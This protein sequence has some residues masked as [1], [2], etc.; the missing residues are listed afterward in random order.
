MIAAEASVQST[1]MSRLTAMIPGHILTPT[2]LLWNQ[3]G[4]KLGRPTR[5]S[6]GHL[7][8]MARSA[9]NQFA[10]F[11]CSVVADSLGMMRL[12]PF[13]LYLAVYV[14]ALFEHR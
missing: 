11:E 14:E 12:A 8:S 3:I 2:N 7:P 6:S 10:A 4:D 13:D 1:A 9:H 5:G